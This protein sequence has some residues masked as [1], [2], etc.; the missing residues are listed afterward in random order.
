MKNIETSH[1]ETAVRQDDYNMNL[2]KEKS[3]EKCNVYEEK[4]Q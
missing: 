3:F 4:L 2:I 1:L